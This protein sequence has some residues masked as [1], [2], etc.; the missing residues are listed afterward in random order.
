MWCKR[1]GFT[2]IVPVM[3]EWM[4]QWYVNVP[5]VGNCRRNEA[6]GT[7]V[8]LFHA[9]PLSSVDVWLIASSFRHVTYCP[10]WIVTEPGEKVCVAIIR[11]SAP[12]VTVDALPEVYAGA[13]AVSV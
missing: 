3:P 2:T 8:P 4:A 11:T 1:Y 13:F 9:G 10:D 7:T 6:P 12:V 5:A